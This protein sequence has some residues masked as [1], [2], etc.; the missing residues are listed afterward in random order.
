[1]D[2]RFH[3]FTARF[4]DKRF[5]DVCRFLYFTLALFNVAFVSQTNL[6]KSLGKKRKT[7]QIIHEEIRKDTKEEK[8]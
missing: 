8:L 6:H 1:M 2:F 3:I 4:A 7:Q 5:V